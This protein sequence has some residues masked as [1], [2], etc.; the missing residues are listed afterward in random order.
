MG[1]HARIHR[2]FQCVLMVSQQ[3]IKH[4]LGFCGTFKRNTIKQNSRTLISFMELWPPLVQPLLLHHNHHYQTTTTDDS[5]IFASSTFF[6]YQFLKKSRRKTSFSHLPLSVPETHSGNIWALPCL[7]LACCSSWT[8]N[9]R[10][11]KTRKNVFQRALGQR[12]AERGLF[13]Y[14]FVIVRVIVWDTWLDQNNLQNNDSGKPFFWKLLM[15]SWN[16][17]E[18]AA[19]NERHKVQKE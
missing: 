1:S 18:A 12:L 16:K 4:F 14:C 17:L 3:R 8:S 7:A 19:E 15:L 6:D 9:V 5:F 13:G 2:I 11:E 10:Q